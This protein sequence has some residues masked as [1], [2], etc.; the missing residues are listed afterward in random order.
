M[1]MNFIL[2]AVNK[3]APCFSFPLIINFSHWYNS[4][5]VSLSQDLL[6]WKL[7]AVTAHQLSRGH[8]DHL[9]LDGLHGPDPEVLLLEGDLTRHVPDEIIWNI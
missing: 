8:L 7:T 4:H 3:E 6:L 5:L 9:I 1:E 2:V